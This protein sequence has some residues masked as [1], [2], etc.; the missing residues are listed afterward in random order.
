VIG[1]SGFS[2]YAPAALAVVLLST[3]VLPGILLF[4]CMLAVASLGK[5]LIELLHLEYVPRTAML[6]L[7]VGLGI[8]LTVFIS[9]WIPGGLFTHF[10]V[11]PLLILVLLSEDFIGIQSELRLKQAIS[12]S[13]QIMVLAVG[14]TLIMG[15]IEIQRFA[16]QFPELVIVAVAVFNFAVGKYLGLRLTEYLRFKPI[17]DTEE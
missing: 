9:T 1:L 7:F 14:S 6:L 11:F 17:I 5:K 10:D 3:G 2:I 4:M 12:R 15:S 13:L 16:L 8:F